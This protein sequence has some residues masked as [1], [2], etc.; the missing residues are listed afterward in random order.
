MEAFLLSYLDLLNLC[1]LQFSFKFFFLGLN[2]LSSIVQAITALFRCPILLA[3][4]AIVSR[5]LS[6]YAGVEWLIG[7]AFALI[8]LTS[9]LVQ[10]WTRFSLSV[11]NSIIFLCN[12]SISANEWILIWILRDGNFA[13]LRDVSIIVIYLITFFFLTIVFKGIR[14]PSCI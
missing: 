11:R 12:E 9:H 4:E 14:V 7:A 13:Q 10:N 8:C 6:T 1:I 2:D 5:L 3:L